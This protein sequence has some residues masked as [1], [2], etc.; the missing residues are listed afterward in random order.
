MDSSEH[1][2]PRFGLD[3]DRAAWSE[4][5]RATARERLRPLAAEPL[6]DPGPSLAPPPPAAPAG[7]GGRVNRPLLAALAGAG[8]IARALP[9]DRPPSALDLCVLRESLAR[10]CT[11]AETA[12][13]LQGLGA[14]PLLSA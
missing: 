7:A 12:L 10:E 11:E 14:H 13:A 2:V 4:E 9:E 3:P 6:T 8:L 5:V 1:P